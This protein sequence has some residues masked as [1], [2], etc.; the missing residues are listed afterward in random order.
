MV[1]ALPSNFFRVRQYGLLTT[2]ESLSAVQMFP[3]VSVCLPVFNGEEF[4]VA[5]IE[6]V[7]GQTFSDFELIISDDCS[8]DQSLKIIEQY[9][10]LDRR[11]KYW[12]NNSKAG[13]FG[14]Y[15]L[16]IEAARGEYIKPFAQDDL[17][18]SDML[19]KLLKVLDTNTDVALVS[20]AR[21]QICPKGTR[22]TS[23][24]PQVTPADLFPSACSVSGRQVVKTLLNPVA[25]FIGE[26][27]T[28]M[29]RKKHVGTGFDPK[30]Y[31]LGDLEYWFRILLNGRY[32]FLDEELCSFRMHAGSTTTTNHK[33][34]L[35]ASDLLRI[36]RK[37]KRFIW[38]SGG[39]QTSF[40]DQIIERVAN[41]LHARGESFKASLLNIEPDYLCEFDEYVS[42]EPLQSIPAGLMELALQALMRVPAE[43]LQPSRRRTASIYEL[44]RTL[45]TYLASS[46]WKVTRFLREINKTFI[47]MDFESSC[48]DTTDDD[49]SYE[50]FLRIQLRRVKRS[51]SW[52]ITTP[53]RLATRWLEPYFSDR[54]YT[55][56]LSDRSEPSI[57]QQS[58]TKI[59][60][61][62]C[63]CHL[64]HLITSSMPA[65]K[66]IFGS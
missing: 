19:E 44:E 25:N 24:T 52:K 4:L 47:D 60:F 54:R 38:E 35:Y 49:F 2:L 9:A 27:T 20:A 37:Y 56:L 46:S 61:A 41:D 17:L 50:R 30:F 15:N 26:P 39:T 8:T 62:N 33:Y 57:N 6:S 58:R 12:S 51:R 64:S 23:Q 10:A 48:S 36:G 3:R 42:K 34:M 28:V 66:S 65:L 7:L 13:L 59:L 1:I 21:S 55:T 40:N 14:N 32:F 16:C 18:H 11:I 45:Q 63:L 31:H 5:A 43:Q 22:I 29:Y 53:L